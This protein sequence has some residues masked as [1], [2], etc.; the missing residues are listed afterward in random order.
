MKNIIFGLLIIL[1]IS[2]CRKLIDVDT[3]KNQLTTEKVFAD[4]SSATAALGDIYAQ[5]N[6]TCES[7]LNINMD[8]YADN[9]TYTGSTKQT[10][11]FYRS[12]VSSDNTANLTLWQ[13][14]YFVVYQCNDLI[15]Q[16]SSSAKIPPSAVQHLTGEAL[17]LR[18]Y[19]YFILVNIYGRVPLITITDVNANSQAGQVVESVVYQQII[20]DLTVA[21]KKLTTYYPGGG[22]ERANIWAAQALLAKVYLCQKNWLLAESAATAV[23]NSNLYSLTSCGNT[24]LANSN[25]TILQFWNLT[26]FT[27]SAVLL[28]PSSNTNLPQY[29]VSNSLL[30]SFEIGDLR[31]ISWLGYNTVFNGANTSSYAYYK[32][33]QNRM[34]NTSNP[35]Y[36]SV[37]RIAE[38]YLIRAEARANQNKIAGSTGAEADINI[39]RNRAGLPNTQATDKTSILFAIAQ[40]RRVELFGEW[41]NRF[42]DLKRNETVDVIVG[43]QKATWVST[44]KVLPIP[45][46]E[47]TYD[48]HLI[49]NSGY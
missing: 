22:R 5:M 46:N 33:Y 43:G 21:T 35:E 1:G 10:L 49:Q 45:L 41:A 26:G 12:K 3:P 11:E 18:A 14:L 28:A 8:L 32:K 19:T 31:K 23:I 30:N 39:I 9:L 37:L 24:F 2:G 38:L 17:F 20:S 15:E 36:L 16:L 13:N 44:A 42:L 29:T 6:K 47:L 48:S 27:T 7:N 34:Q 25:E 40:E 4:T